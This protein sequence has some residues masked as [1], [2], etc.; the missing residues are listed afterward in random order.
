MQ[1]L[2][3]LL[4]LFSFLTLPA[5]AE[6]TEAAEPVAVA[7]SEAAVPA[8]EEGTE[9]AEPAVAEGTEAAE[10][11]AAEETEAAEPAV[12]EETETAAPV[13]LE[14][15]LEF[16]DFVVAIGS[17]WVVENEKSENEAIL[18]S[19]VTIDNKIRLTFFLSGDGDEDRI[20]EIAAVN[21]YS[22]GIVRDRT[23]EINGVK[24]I[25]AVG[26]EMNSAYVYF[27]INGHVY[28]VSVSSLSGD[29]HVDQ[30][31]EKLYEIMKTLTV[32]KPE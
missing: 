17:D 21:E 11:A 30:L 20:S 31:S 13:V 3:C 8:A 29:D 25:F 22:S 32:R 9:A 16:E 2:I 18:V 4:L 19:A 24:Y 10:P 26:K 12:A 15:E 27:S 23:E 1:R 7:E 5:M 14:T 28:T 6:G